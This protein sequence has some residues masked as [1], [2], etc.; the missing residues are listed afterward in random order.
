[1]IIKYAVN[2]PNAK[3]FPQFA[4]NEK[5]WVYL[6][7]VSSFTLEENVVDNKIQKALNIEG[8]T[9]SLTLYVLDVVYIM[10]NEG[11]TIEVIRPWRS[12][13]EAIRPNE[14]TL[15]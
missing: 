13:D 1:M 11:R 5:S 6:D 9:N 12:P 4:V 10:N 2:N 3:E 8:T 14:K 7:D 15:G